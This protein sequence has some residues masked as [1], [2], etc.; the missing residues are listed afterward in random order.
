MI[1]DDLASAVRAN[2][3]LLRETFAELVSPR[4]WAE[5]GALAAFLTV[6]AI[7]IA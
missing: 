4:A 1:H 3:A 5:L 2:L 7:C 6:F